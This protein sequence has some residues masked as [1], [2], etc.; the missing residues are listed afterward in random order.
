M[1]TYYAESPTRSAEHLVFNGSYSAFGSPIDKVQYRYVSAILCFVERSHVRVRSS[2]GFGSFVGN[3]VR[4]DVI[5]CY[6]RFI[7]SGHGFKKLVEKLNIGRRENYNFAF[8]IKAN[9]K[10]KKNLY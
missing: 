4:N 5:G 2:V 9:K 3:I 10:N 8:R 6:V 7:M 1:A